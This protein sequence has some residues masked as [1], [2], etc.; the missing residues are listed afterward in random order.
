ME[1]RHFLKFIG[2]STCLSAY[3]AAP[4]RAG[5]S[6]RRVN[7]RGKAGVT[8]RGSA[9]NVILVNLQG[10]ITHVDTFDVKQGDWTPED[11]QITDHGNFLWPDGL[12]PNLAAHTDKFSLLRAMSGFEQVHQ[13]AAYLVETAQT[14]NPTFSKEHPHIGSIMAM[15]L[16]SQ[17]TEADLMP[18]FLAINARVQG[19]GM[20]STSYQAFPIDPQNGVAGLEH[21]AGE[22]V[23]NARWQMLMDTDDA[24]FAQA[25][26][27]ASISDYHNYYTAAER[28]M[29]R[30]ELEGVFEI[31]PENLARYGETGVGAGCAVA[32]QTLARNAGARVV[33]VNHGGWDHHNDIYTPDVLYAST[34]ELDSALAALFEDLAATPGVR[35]GTLLDETMVVVTGEFGRTPGAL[36]GNAGRDHYPYAYASLVAGGGIVPGQA[37]GATDREGWAVA[38]QFWSQNRYLTMEDL[39]AT[40]YS[41]LGIDWTKEILDTPSGRAYEYTPKYNGIQGYY[42]DIKEM[43]G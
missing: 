36:S 8:P 24:R 20:L 4:L 39:V 17:R 25:A 29:Y 18:T 12:F 7:V 23:F 37:F 13:R 2:A 11:F 28:M 41:S 40:M 30:S 27:G 21:P 35:G 6:D 33:Q 34:A 5:A 31:S 16:A 19:A 1:R 22:A 26:Q 9:R 15:E 32:Y 3:A 14:F 10:G 42:T 43:F 38:D